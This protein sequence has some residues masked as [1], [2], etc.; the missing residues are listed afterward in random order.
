[1]NPGVEIDAWLLDHL[2]CP[3][4][5]GPLVQRDER[6]VCASC[7]LAFPIRDGIPVLRLEE[8]ALPEGVDSLEA[9][10][11]APRENAPS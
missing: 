7:G 5:K 11:C 6:L 9:L 3:A 4:G 1:M 8:A 10:R 2:R